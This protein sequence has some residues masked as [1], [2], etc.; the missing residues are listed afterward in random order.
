MQYASHRSPFDHIPVNMLSNGHTVQKAHGQHPSHQDASTVTILPGDQ[1][2]GN[3][4]VE[5]EVAL[6]LFWHAEQIKETPNILATIV[7][8]NQ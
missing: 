2:W 6:P 1:I 8:D 3:L 5:A 7:K 4:L